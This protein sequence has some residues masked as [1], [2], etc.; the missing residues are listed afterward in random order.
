MVNEGVVLA[1]LA[2][3][4]SADGH[5][6]RKDYTITLYVSSKKHAEIIVGLLRKYTTRKIGIRKHH[7]VY[8]VYVTDKELALVF[9]NKYGVSKGRK[10][11]RI[12]LPTLNDLE[13]RY[14]IAGFFDGD[15][16]IY[17]CKHICKYGRVSYYYEI[18]IKSKSI[19]FLKQIQKFMKKYG[20]SFRLKNYSSTIPYLVLSRRDQVLLFFKT[21]PTRFKRPQD[22]LP[23]GAKSYN[24]GRTTSGEG[25]RLERARR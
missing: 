14:F 25:A 20:V 8:E 16:S 15:G 18:K 13:T 10:Y 11:D 5:I 19:V 17:V 1:Y 7:N 2:G 4:I 23:Q 24:P 22:P 6:K 12:V 21:I 9:I 3:L